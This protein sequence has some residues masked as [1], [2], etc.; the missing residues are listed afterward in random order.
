VPGTGSTEREGFVL[1]ELGVDE[2][3]SMT[4]GADDPVIERWRRTP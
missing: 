2:T 4:Y 1:Y 3:F